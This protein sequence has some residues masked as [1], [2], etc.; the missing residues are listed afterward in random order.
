MYLY[1][2]RYVTSEMSE[3]WKCIQ[4]YSRIQTHLNQPT[5]LSLIAF[6][7]NGEGIT[8]QYTSTR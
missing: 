7:Y 4:K 5:Y 3:N 1:R 6:E 8:L 2:S